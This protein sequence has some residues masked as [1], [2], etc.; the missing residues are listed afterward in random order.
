LSQGQPDRH[1]FLLAHEYLQPSGIHTLYDGVEQDGTVIVPWKE[2]SRSET[3]VDASTA[4][5]KGLEQ[6]IYILYNILF[7]IYIKNNIYN[8]LYNI[9]IY[10]K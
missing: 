2:K 7:L 10:G 6:D 4:K 5:T 3:S 8:I 9:Y 1:F